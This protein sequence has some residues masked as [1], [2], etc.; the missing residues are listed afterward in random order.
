VNGQL[1]QPSNGLQA[2]AAEEGKAIIALPSTAAGGKFS[3]IAISLKEGVQVTTARSHVRTVA[4][5]YGV[6]E[7]FGQS[8]RVMVRGRATDSSPG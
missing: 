8:R 6:A 4:T 2:Q 7:L 3:R 5:E 1:A